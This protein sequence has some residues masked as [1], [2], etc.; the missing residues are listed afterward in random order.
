[1][2]TSLPITPLRT[3]N[4]FDID[5]SST[6]TF[7]IKFIQENH[8]DEAINFMNEFF[9][10]DEPMARVRN[11]KDDHESMIENSAGWREILK[12]KISI[13]CFKRTKDDE[14]IFIK[15]PF[16]YFRSYYYWGTIIYHITLMYVG[17]H[18]S[19]IILGNNN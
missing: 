8:Y 19:M 9:L 15:K 1:M 12:Y 11:F 4:A 16:S 18:F 14:E 13:A 17:D 10:A 6:V 5:G 2:A 7:E 3:F